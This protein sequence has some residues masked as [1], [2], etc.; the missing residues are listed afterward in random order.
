MRDGYSAVIRESSKQLSPK[1]KLFALQYA[2]A[3]KLDEVVQG[4][5]P[6]VI[7]N[8]EFYV[9]LD[10]HNEKAV[11]NIDYTI[12]V[13]TDNNGVKYCTGSKSFISDFTEIWIAMTDDDTGEFYEP[14]GVEVV[15]MPSKNYKG[16]SFLKCSVC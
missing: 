15:K 8:P 11:D 3:R 7:D 16:K 10:V 2:S 13:I 6:F 1:E 12:I 5:E 14:W 9:V 4:S